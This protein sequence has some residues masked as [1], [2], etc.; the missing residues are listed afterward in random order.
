MDSGAKSEEEF[1][2]KDRD[3]VMVNMTFM[4]E[5]YK[6]GL[7]PLR[8]LKSSADGLVTFIREHMAKSQFSQAELHCLMMYYLI[9]TVGEYMDKDKTAKPLLESYMEAIKEF[10]SHKGFEMRVRFLLRDVVDD[11][12]NDWRPR[13]RFEGPMKLGDVKELYDADLINPVL[14]TT[15][16]RVYAPSSDFDG[17]KQ[18]KTVD[19]QR[20]SVSPAKRGGK[21]RSGSGTKGNMPSRRS[22]SGGASSS[23]LPFGTI[24]EPTYAPSS[25]SPTPLNININPSLSPPASGPDSPGIRSPGNPT[26]GVNWDRMTNW[27]ADLVSAA[28]KDPSENSDA[29]A[30]HLQKHASASATD[31]AAFV[32]KLLSWILDRSRSEQAKLPILL[33][34]LVNCSALSSSDITLGFTLLV[35]TLDDLTMDVPQAPALIGRRV[36]ELVSSQFAILSPEQRTSIVAHCPQR[37][38][39]RFAAEAMAEIK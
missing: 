32:S 16:E 12:L 24:K 20:Q 11:R 1:S 26:A 35:Q 27:P 15:N 13:R 19:Q 3:R 10:A 34:P 4:G 5:L 8:V 25:T 30:I 21:E 6:Q 39:D 23:V 36:A 18:P 28:L 2:Y 17:P 29:L 37:F 22:G 33:Q 31:R 14:L 38:S 7:I 9:R